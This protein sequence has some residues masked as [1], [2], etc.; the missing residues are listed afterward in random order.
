VR[1][2]TNEIDLKFFYY[3]VKYIGLN[4]LKDGTSNP[5]LT[6]DTFR[7]L[8]LPL[9]PRQQQIRIRDILSTIDDKLELN[10]RTNE[11]LESMTR[12]LFQSWFVNFDPVHRKAAVR[13]VHPKWT[14]AQVSSVALPNLAAEVAEVFPDSFVDST[15]GP[16]PKGW[17][18]KSLPEAIDVNPSRAIAK[19]STVAWLEMANVPTRSTRALAWER[20]EFGSGTKFTNGDTLVARIT[21]CLENGKT[22]FVDFLQEGEVGA[23]STEFIVLRPKPPLP[24][25]FAYF[26]ARNEDFRQHLITNMTGTSGRQRAPA[27]CLKAY[28]LVVPPENL[29][30]HFGEF[31][32]RSIAQMKAN[33]EQSNELLATRETLLPKLLSGDQTLFESLPSEN[34][35]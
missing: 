23:G 10:R 2:I 21:P 30:L 34:R 25:T 24:T 33:D 11:T 31:A 4:H 18:A 28:P 27:D 7:L 26:L 22:A 35:Q 20:R 9:P 12:T 19:G 32:E 5:S 8:L 3:L 29:A 17:I 15:H 6:R 16:I 14:N 13:R 1:P